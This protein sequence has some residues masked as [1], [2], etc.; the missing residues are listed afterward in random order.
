M[1]DEN[2]DLSTIRNQI[3]DGITAPLFKDTLIG[4][5]YMDLKYAIQDCNNIFVGIINTKSMSDIKGLVDKVINKAKM[6]I[7]DCKKAYLYVE[8][9]ISLMELNEIAVSLEE[10]MVDGSNIA[11]T[12]SYNSNKVD[13]YYVMVLFGL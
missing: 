4:L 5:D 1:T 8:G 13:E 7:D 10:S 2:N 3:L 6:K 11:F 9:D 12:A